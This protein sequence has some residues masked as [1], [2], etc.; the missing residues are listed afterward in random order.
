MNM[1]VSRR[2]MLG[3]LAVTGA[4]VA[5]VRPALALADSAPAF[6]ATRAFLNG[7]V[8]RKQL[9]GA[10]A[11]IGRGM[12]APHYLAAGA[13]AL[14]GPVAVDQNSLWRVYSMTKPV[15]GI[16][17]MILVDRGKLRLD[18]PIADLL[19]AYAKM[20][21]QV[22]PDGSIDDVRPAKTMITLRHLLTHTAGL[23]YTIIQKGPLVEAYRKQG[24]LPG[25]VTRL[26]LPGIDNSPAAPSLAEFADRLATLPLVYEP[27]TRWSYSVSLD[28]LGRVIE[29]A[30]GKA[31]DT[32]LAR[33]A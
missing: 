27:G 20:Q 15:T 16:A 17:A 21:V 13:T 5:T 4:F 29:V 22:T 26:P 9:A 30:S 18:Q 14:G 31:F 2:A 25:K 32:C 19:P 1:M 3:G 10:L 6:P 7:F 33:S 24:I 8:E 11:S 12:G 23:G 28:L